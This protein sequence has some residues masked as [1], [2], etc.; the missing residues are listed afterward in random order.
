MNS[1][2]LLS[3]ARILGVPTEKFQPLSGGHVSRV[4]GF[5]RDGKDLVLRLIPFGEDMDA[6]A[7]QAIMGWVKYLSDNGAAVI[8]PV[9]FDDGN[10]VEVIPDEDGNWLAVVCERAEGVLS[11]TLPMEK[12]DVPL[13]QT[14]GQAVG[15]MHALA[16][17]YIPT[18]GMRRPEWDAA[19]N[20]FNRPAL[21]Q[22][23]LKPKQAAVLERIRNLPRG[24]DE[25]HL[26]HA[27]L[28]FANFFVE[29]RSR[30]I[31]LF[32]FDDSCYGWA[33]MDIAILLFDAIV[34]YKGQDK[35]AFARH[36]MRNFLSG[37]KTENPIG[38]FWTTQIPNFLKLLE[39]NLYDEVAPHFNP[40]G[41]DPWVNSFIPGR[42]RR[43]QN[44]QPYVDIDFEILAVVRPDAP[45]HRSTPPPEPKK[46]TPKI[47]TPVTAELKDTALIAD[48]AKTRPVWREV[49]AML[50]VQMFTSGKLSADRAADMAGLSRVEF[51][52][53][54]GFYKIFPLMD[55]L[56]ELE[57]LHE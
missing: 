26:I 43:I 19:G 42:K 1:E 18:A 51:L 7:Q 37:Y 48:R 55:E 5:E 54:L 47:Q 50:A 57:N 17:G 13:V 10:L 38:I 9:P 32:D 45:I 16:K 11:E 52:L 20:L 56:N 29:P 28:H 12:W 2:I 36:F 15:R 25:Y 53:G 22:D 6:Q 44:D 27:D 33:A 39:I 35:D 14:F 24:G 49:R 23:W 46:E 30:L 40:D 41:G 21:D 31:T 3:A 4:Y 34:M 8:T